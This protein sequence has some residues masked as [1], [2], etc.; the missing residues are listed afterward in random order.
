MLVA[1]LLG[2][3]RVYYLDTALH[4]QTKAATNVVCINGYSK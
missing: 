1:T 2:P 4:S 3:G